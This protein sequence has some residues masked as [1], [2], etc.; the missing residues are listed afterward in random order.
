L[1]VATPGCRLPRISQ[2]DLP[3]ALVAIHYRTPEEAR[4]HAED[5]KAAMQAGARRGRG[6]REVSTGAGIAH[7][8]DLGAYLGGVFGAVPGV[9]RPQSGRLALLDPRTGEVTVVEAALRG[10][11]PLAWSADRQRLL[12]AQPG[13]TD[14]QLWELRRGSDT[15]RPVTRGP[16]AH[17]QGCYG[18]DGRIVVV[19]VDVRV[20][21]RRSWI[22]VSAEGGRSPFTP[23]SSGPSDHSPTCTRHGGTVAYVRQAEGGQIWLA[24]LYSAAEPRMLASGSQ[25]R[26]SPAGDWIA[27]VVPVQGMRRLWRMRPDG[28]ARAPIGRGVREESNPAISPD[29]RFVAYVAAE[30]EFRRQLYLRRFDGSGERILFA[31]G[32][33]GLPVW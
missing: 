29:G 14:V 23:I 12:F 3:E 4:L 20:K 6:S 27:F 21:P 8:D 28:S 25:P 22:A 9:G 5:R 16:L 11:I 24:Q 26:L 1:L 10:S 33:G 17:S 15:V 7:S 13:G 30:K 32:D 18:P 2:A 31:D 19:E